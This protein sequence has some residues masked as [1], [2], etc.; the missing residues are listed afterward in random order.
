MYRQKYPKVTTLNGWGNRKSN[1]HAHTEMPTV[2]YTRS[3]LIHRYS[4]DMKR[5]RLPTVTL[6]ALMLL[7]AGC[8]GAKMGTSTATPL[9]A[10]SVDFPDG[11]KEP[12]ER[13]T[14]L[15]RSAVR[16]YVKT[17]E[18]RIVYNT[19]WV[20]EYTEVS[21]ACRIDEVSKQSWGYEAVVTCTGY[22][23]TDIPKNTTQTPGP[24]ADW[25]TQ[26]Y[27]YRVNENT[28]HRRQVD[29]QEPVA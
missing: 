15:N 6:L 26:S 19:L 8:A 27:Q 24:H 13:P 2:V 23:N 16:Q 9:P 22:S 28:T 12:P 17:F 10:R 7:T 29:A 18:Y 5:P 3:F 21:L 11:P 14:S 1:R 20:N 4:H 25:F